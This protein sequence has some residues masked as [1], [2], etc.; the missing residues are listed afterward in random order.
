MTCGDVEPEEVGCP[1]CEKPI[2][3][4]LFFSHDERQVGR[5]QLTCLS[6]GQLLW[7][8]ATDGTITAA[9]GCGDDRRELLDML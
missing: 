8:S 6:C 3:L 9:S 1:M 5:K 7:A 2:A 4:P